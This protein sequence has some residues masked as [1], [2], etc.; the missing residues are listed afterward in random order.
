MVRPSAYESNA[1]LYNAVAELNSG[2]TPIAS[3]PSFLM[4]FEDSHRGNGLPRLLTRAVVERAGYAR[5]S[6]NFW[7]NWARYR[8][9]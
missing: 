7:K 3:M 8:S 2:S 4:R 1:E 5:L 6:L 9:T